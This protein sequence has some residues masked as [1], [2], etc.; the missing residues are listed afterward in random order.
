MTVTMN[1]DEE[2]PEPDLTLVALEPELGSDRCCEKHGLLCSVTDS[3]F[4]ACCQRCPEWN[5][6]P[7]WH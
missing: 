6:E 4:D 2:E 5:G 3:G 7:E 1:H